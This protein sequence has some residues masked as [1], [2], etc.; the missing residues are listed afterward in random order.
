MRTIPLTMERL[1]VALRFAIL[2]AGC[3]AAPL[4]AQTIRLRV[5]QENSGL[6]VAAAIVDVL[7]TQGTV[8]AQ[9]VLSPDGRRIVKLP[10]AGTYRVRL[11][12]IGFEPFFADAIAVA[13]QSTVDVALQAPQRRVTLGAIRVRGRRCAN[14]ALD[15][16]GLFALWEEIRKALTTTLLTRE[17][18]SLVLEARAFHRTLDENRNV[19]EELVGL[20]RTIAARRPYVART[21]A[22]LSRRGYVRV[23]GDGAEYFAPDEQVLLSDEFLADHCF[24][25]ARSVDAAAGLLGVRFSP[26]AGEGRSTNDISGTLWVDSASAE[27]RYLDFWYEHKTM[28]R[29]VLGED[30]S[31]GQIVFERVPNGLWIVSAWRLRM[32]RFKKE[33]T[34]QGTKVNLLTSLEG[35]DEQGGVVMPPGTDTLPPPAV[36]IPY[37]ALLAPARITGTVFDSLAN[38]PLVGASV[39]LIP[40]EPASVVDAGLAPSGGRL[41][42]VPVADTTDTKGRFALRAIPAG[43]YRLGF[44]HPALDTLGLITTRFDIRLRPGA[45]VAAN[46]GVPSRAALAVGCGRPDGMSPKAVAGVVFGVVRAANDQRPLANALVR[47][48]WV[49]LSRSSANMTQTFVAETRTDTNG[50]YRLCGVPDSTFATVQ[51]AGPHSSTGE[52]RTKIGPLGVVNVD[53]RLAEVAEGEAPPTPGTIFGTVTDSLNRPITHARVTLDGSAIEA[54][55]DAAGRF[56]LAGVMPGTQTIEVRRVGLEGVRRAV[57]VTPGAT[58]TMALTLEKAQLLDAMIVTAERTKRSPRVV[59]AFRRHRTGNGKLIPEE[60]IKQ[61]ATV[62]SVVQGLAGVRVTMGQGNVSNGWVAM[63]RQGEKECIARIFIDGL[64]NDYDFLWTLNPDQV[65]A[66]EVFV[67]PGT[68]PIFTAGHTH[69]TNRPVRLPGVEFL[70]G[71]PPPPTPGDASTIPRDETC[72]MLLFWLKH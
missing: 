48:S 12:R 41:A 70:G 28:P 15:D 44:E 18:S 38:Q 51:A 14:D 55:T 20:P 53:L 2:G 4:N 49:E 43:S 30:K 39:W 27:L 72:G 34:G 58:M 22:D 17:D 5:T 13:A 25:V 29:Q 7:D 11:R 71:P 40:D 36:L 21:A 59:E 60:E 42:V 54:Q 37:R 26:A 62:Q 64:E 46:L 63:L 23:S 32:P 66:V 65:E 67:R 3:I 56:H 31:G 9:S 50:V 1:L 52:V 57:D 47:I 33:L 10:A 24:E 68:A 35:Y 69:F 16:P 45:T 61:H 6:P 8:V 19:T